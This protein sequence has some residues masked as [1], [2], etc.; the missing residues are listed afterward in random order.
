[1]GQQGGEYEPRD[2]RNVTGTSTNQTGD[3]WSAEAQEGKTP[4]AAGSYGRM[5]DPE[6]EEEGGLEIMFEPDPELEQQVTGGESH[7][8]YGSA[9]AEQIEEHMDVIG[10]DGEHVG[11]VDGVEGEQIKLTRADSGTDTDDGHRFLPIE[12]VSAVEEGQVRLATSAAQARAR[13]VGD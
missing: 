6:A 5:D 8:S 12:L 3:R 9:F 4:N 1:M 7:V 10:A 11:T 2:S 13:V